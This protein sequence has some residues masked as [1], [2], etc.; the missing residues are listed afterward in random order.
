MSLYEYNKRYFYHAHHLN[1]KDFRSSVP[2]METKTK[3]VFLIIYGYIY[4][5]IYIYIEASLIAQLVKNP[6]AVQETP[7]RFQGWEDSPG[8]GIGY[9]L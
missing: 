9:P 2:E 5:Y 7:V 8:E 3:H 6:P 1:S 4:I